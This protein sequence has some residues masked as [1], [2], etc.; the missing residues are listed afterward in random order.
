MDIK[1]IKEFKGI[2]IYGGE[3]IGKVLIFNNKVIKINNKEKIILVVPAITPDLVIYFN[4]IKA[5]ISEIGSALSH[6]SILAREYGLPTII[7][8]NATQLFKDEHLI[9]MNAYLGKVK[10]IN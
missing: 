5:L 6:G 7:L 1:S 10:I 9:K 8:E 3:V 2:S 4:S